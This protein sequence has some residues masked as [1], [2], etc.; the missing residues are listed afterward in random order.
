MGTARQLA[1]TT[2]DTY[3]TAAALPLPKDYS[4]D[5][6]QSD[7]R[8]WEQE[9]GMTYDQYLR[10]QKAEG[11]QGRPGGWAP[12]LGISRTCKIFM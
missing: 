6:W 10:S 9:T 11:P 1:A 12:P 7:V 2:S 8:R 4:Y 3:R 5:Q